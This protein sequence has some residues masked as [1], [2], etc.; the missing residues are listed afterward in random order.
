MPEPS[1][2]GSRSPVPGKGEPPPIDPLLEGRYD[3]QLVLGQLHGVVSTVVETAPSWML[4]DQVEV[5][6]E[7]SA[8]L[9]GSFGA[10]QARLNTGEYDHKLPG[11]GLTGAQAV[12]KKRGFRRALSGWVKA[13]KQEATELVRALKPVLRW[14]RTYVSSLATVV[15]GAEAVGEFLEVVQNSIEDREEEEDQ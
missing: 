6:R 13:R 7:A 9:G 14:G 2:G 11:A 10:T 15:P 3:A 4:S 5:L 12:P 8:E 1:K